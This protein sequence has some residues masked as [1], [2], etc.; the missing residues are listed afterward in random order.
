M[1]AAA[2]YQA[3]LKHCVA[4]TASGESCDDWQRQRSLTWMRLNIGRFNVREKEISIAAQCGEESDRERER[5]T[6]RE[7][8]SESESESERERERERERARPPCHNFC[9]QC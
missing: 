4:S 1:L 8:E 6:E 7:R 5:E 2:T 9:P 3:D